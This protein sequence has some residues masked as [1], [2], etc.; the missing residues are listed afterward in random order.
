MHLN[1]DRGSFLLVDVKHIFISAE[2]FVKFVNTVIVVA[3]ILRATK[4]LKNIR[5]NFYDFFK[6]LMLTGSFCRRPV[7]I[8]N[9]LKKFII[10]NVLWKLIMIK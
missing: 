1:S 8:L 2:V 7:L 10:T 9:G 4:E 5:D 3:V 6:S